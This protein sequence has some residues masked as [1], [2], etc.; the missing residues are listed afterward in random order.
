VG[1]GDEVT[2]LMLYLSRS[3]DS[4]ICDRGSDKLAMELTVNGFIRLEASRESGRGV[5]LQGCL[6]GKSR[7]LIVQSHS[8]FECKKHDIRRSPV[9]F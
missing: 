4:K 1:F 7:R 3:F 2:L 8:L 5:R 9:I 6:F